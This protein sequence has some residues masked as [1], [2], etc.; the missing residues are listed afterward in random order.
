MKTDERS[1][2]LHA[3]LA[4]VGRGLVVTKNSSIRKIVQDGTSNIILS[5]EA[6]SDASSCLAAI[7]QRKFEI[8]F[9]DFA[10]EH[11]AELAVEHLRNTPSTQNAVLIGI[12]SNAQHARRAFAT[13]VT[14][15]VQEPLS[16]TNLQKVMGAAYG[17]VLRERRRYFRCYVE[18][19]LTA[20]RGSE[21]VWRGRLTNI[22]ENGVCITA[23][24]HLPP[25]ENMNIRTRIPA[26]QI[27]LSAECEVLW[28]DKANRAG[29]RFIGIPDTEREELQHWLTDQ[30]DAA[31]RS[32]NSLHQL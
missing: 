27:K 20:S 8:V 12:V 11:E 31:L 21:P 14:F 30:L 10:L 7:S 26:T 9:I 18:A 1:R 24:F 4:N 13:G 23:P 22:S 17:L 3:T 2:S 16:T 15:L 19:P 28:S 6:C 32:R 29:L 5:S 25:G